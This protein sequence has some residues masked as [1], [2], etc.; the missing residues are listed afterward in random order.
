MQK[1]MIALALVGIVD[2]VSYMVVAPSIIF[3]VLQAGGTKEQ[4]GVILSAFSFASFC[5]KPFLGAWS[6][7]GG[8]RIPYMTSLAISAVGGILYLCASLYTGRVAVGLMLVGR[9]MGGVGGASSALGFAYM[10]KVVEHKDQTKTTSLLSMVRIMGM[11]GGP[12]V[13]VLLGKIDAHWRRL[14]LDPLNSV[15]LVLL[16]ANVFGFL[17]IYFLLDEPDPSA[18]LSRHSAHPTEST[19]RSDDENPSSI[20]ASIRPVL[21]FEIWLFILSIF[22]FNASFQLVE[23]GFA[24]A[25]SHAMGWGPVGTSTVMGSVSIMIALNMFVVYQLSARHVSDEM[26]LQIG[27]YI[28]IAGY[29]LMWALWVWHAPAWQFVL[30]IVL[31]A[32]SFPFLAAPTRSC[33]T[34][35]V[36]AIPELQHMQGTMQAVLSMAASVAGFATPGLVAAYV[37]RHPDEVVTSRDHRELNQTALIAPLVSF[38][39]LMGLYM[40]QLRGTTKVMDDDDDDKPIGE[41]TSLLMESQQKQQPTVGSRTFPTQVEVHRRQSTSTMGGIIVQSS[42][43]GEHD[44]PATTTE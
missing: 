2:A 5:T 3:Y 17:V 22:S 11:A 8:Y 25:A 13:N 37:L 44:P 18:M 43:V 14:H 7:K 4:Y 29:T 6:D 20:W 21:R 23:T 9:L 40:T 28:S 10:A 16:G 15:G 26:L 12:G 36:D 34:K 30:P 19:M 41:D 27:L 1:F 33:F 24:P 38:L 35:A 32:S 31:G 42:I 39:V